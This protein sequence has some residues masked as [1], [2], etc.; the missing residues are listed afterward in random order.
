MSDFHI[1]LRFIPLKII[2]TV[3]QQGHFCWSDFLRGHL[4]QVH[5]VTRIIYQL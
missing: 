3:N 2:L 4:N 5:F 1:F